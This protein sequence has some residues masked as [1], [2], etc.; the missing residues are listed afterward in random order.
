MEGD[1]GT[2]QLNPTPDAD[3]TPDTSVAVSPDD[4]TESA[5]EEPAEPTSDGRRVSRLGRGWLTAICVTLLLLTAGAGVGGYFALKSHEESSALATAEVEAVRAA[6]DCVAATQAPDTTAMT[7]GQA[8]II[9]CSTGDFGAQA[10]L[11]SGM[12]VDAYRAADVQV[13]VSD[14]RA[15]VE[16]HN[17]DGSID[18]LVAVRVKVSNSE[19]ADQEQGYRLRVQMAPADGTYKVARLDQVTS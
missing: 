7:T 10:A 1:A 15:A 9:E 8:K 17:G 4:T 6:K 5:T 14:M 2:R 19:A 16:K 18:V 11:Y 3:E 13:Q 12:L